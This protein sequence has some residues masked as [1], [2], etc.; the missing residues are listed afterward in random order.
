MSYIRN[1]CCTC[2]AILILLLPNIST[3]AE[4]KVINLTVDYKTVDFTGK[5]VQAIAVNNQIPGPTLHFKEGDH[6]TINVHN[7]L[8]T[9]TA[10]HWHG[11]LLPWQMDG[12]EYVTQRPIPPGGVFHYR[13]TLHQSGTYWYHAHKDLQEQQGLYGALIIASKHQ[14]LHYNK[15]FPIILSDWTNTNPDDVLHRLKKSGDYY[16]PKF[17]L[18]PSLLQYLKDYAH[19]TSNKQRKMITNAYLMMQKGRMSVY[20]FSDV[21]YDAF[22]LNGHTKTS[23]WIGQVKPGDVVRLRFI[24]AMASTIY[25]V[26]IPNTKMQMVQIDGQNVKPHWVKSFTIAPGET[27][28]VLVKIPNQQPK[29]I[30]AESIDKVGAAY[31]ALTV[32]HKP[33]NFDQVKPFPKPLP[34]MMRHH[35]SMGHSLNSIPTNTTKYKYDIST[36]RTNN[37]NIKPHVIKMVLSGYMDRYMWFLNGKPESKA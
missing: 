1:L 11:I 10:I 15:D 30:Y 37:P 23:P 32:N 6:V 16:S 22:L 3:W 5:K 26:K 29:I 14:T 8:K 9:G 35:S 25:H 7:H 24:G 33:I 12:V 4:N 2:M 21:A 28:D 36:V 13:F 19:A 18:Q 17:P 20:D 31:G 27:F 34:I